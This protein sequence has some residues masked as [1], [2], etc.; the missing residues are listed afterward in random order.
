MDKHYCNILA[1]NKNFQQGKIEAALK[2]TFLQVDDM[3][4]TPDAKKEL[5]SLKNSSE[6]DGGMEMES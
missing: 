3:L 1:N 5:R 6:E 4:R 2:E